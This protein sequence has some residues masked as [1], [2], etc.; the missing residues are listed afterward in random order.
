MLR[1]LAITSASALRLPVMTRRSI[2]DAGFAVAVW[3]LA[4]PSASALSNE[5]AP[6]EVV[7]GQTSDIKIGVLDIN[8]SPVADY[9]Q[10]PGLYPNVAG[11]V[12]SHGP[13]K[14]VKDV[15]S[16]VGQHV[17][18]DVLAAAPGPASHLLSWPPSLRWAGLAELP[19]R[20][21]KE[22]PRHTEPVRTTRSS[23]ASL[24]LP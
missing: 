11:K 18:S 14:N 12:A 6:N 23:V 20:T 3:P 2:V 9:M 21:H 5:P 10:Y 19:L 8:N 7:P 17:E 16:A 22:R 4:A 24:T 13:Y 1:L 15:F